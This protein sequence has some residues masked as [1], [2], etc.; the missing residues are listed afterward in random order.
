MPQRIYWSVLTLILTCSVHI[1]AYA[2]NLKHA[3]EVS[4]DENGNIAFMSGDGTRPNFYENDVKVACEYQIDGEIIIFKKDGFDIGGNPVIVSNRERVFLLCMSVNKDY[5]RG[6]LDLAV[7]DL[8]TGNLGP[9]INVVETVGAIPDKPS[10]ALNNKN[11]LALS[12]IEAKVDNGINTTLKIL[13][14]PDLGAHWKAASVPEEQTSNEVIKGPQGNF[15]W[16]VEDKFYTSY[17]FYEKSV[18][19]LIESHDSASS[20]VIISSIR[21]EFDNAEFLPV[22]TK[23]ILSEDGELK[24]ILMYYGHSFGTSLIFPV[25][26]YSLNNPILISNTSTMLD[27]RF[28][29]GHYLLLETKKEDTLVRT[30][31]KKLDIDFSTSRLAVLSSTS[32]H[33]EELYYYG[34]YQSLVCINGNLIAYFIDYFGDHQSL[35]KEAMSIKE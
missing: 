15:T 7:F 16:S 5:S 10:I 27:A 4:A 9:W 18:I 12:Y 11:V 3:Y 32:K 24:G 1:S 31:L 23:S 21:H 22:V 14:S 6:S 19:N 25:K 8:Q 13:K 29:S 2:Q 26:N 17:G 20:F 30:Y 28:V 35:R 33:D 34:A